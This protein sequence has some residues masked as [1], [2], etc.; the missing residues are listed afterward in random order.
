[1]AYSKFYDNFYAWR[2]GAKAS[3]LAV[4]RFKPSRIYG[5]GFI[6][7]Q[8]LAW[9]QVYFIYRNLAGDLLVLHY[10][11]DFG[12]DLVDDPIRIISYP[13]FSLIIFLLNLTIAA[14]LSKHRDF[15]A[16]LH[17]LLGAA[18]V[19]GVFLN[20]ALIFVYLINFR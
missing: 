14:V 15:Q 12:I 13:F 6:F 5:L 4:W 9:F 19:F 2:Q 10:N 7:L 17:I 11:V 1:M 18:L 3:L 16:Y 20:L 8:L